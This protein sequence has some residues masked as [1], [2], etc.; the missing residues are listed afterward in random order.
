[1][2]LFMVTCRATGRKV[3]TG[4]RINGSAWNSDAEFYAFTHCPACEGY[5]EWCA[6]DVILSD[7]GENA[8]FVTVSSMDQ[9]FP[10]IAGVH[11]GFGER[12]R[13]K[14]AASLAKQL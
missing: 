6:N 7:E 14:S 10:E 9:D 8:D 2:A 11:S 13:C 4:V 12:D 1:M 5:H 3:S